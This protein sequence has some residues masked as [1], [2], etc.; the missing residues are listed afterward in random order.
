[1][2]YYLLYLAMDERFIS[3]KQRRKMER[4]QKKERKDTFYRN[5][6]KNKRGRKTSVNSVNSDG[7]KVEESDMEY[8]R[9]KMGKKVEE[10]GK[11]KEIKVKGKVKDVKE[12]DDIDL[13]LEYLEGK[14]GLDKEENMKALSKIY[15][16]ENH[17]PDILDFLDNIDD[18]VTKDVEYY[19]NKKKMKKATNKVEEDEQEE[20]EEG[21]DDEEIHSDEYEDKEED[22]DENEGNEDENI[23]SDEH[24]DNE[25]D[26]NDDEE[27]QPQTKKPPIRK[28]EPAKPKPTK[29]PQTQNKQPPPPITQFQKEITSLLNKISESN[30]SILLPTIFSKITTLT[31]LHPPLQIYKTLTTVSIN[32]LSHPTTSLPI[33]SCICTFLSLCHYKYGDSFLLY[34]LHSLLT[35]INYFIPSPEHPKHKS[36]NAIFQLIHFYLFK[37]I[38]SSLIYDLILYFIENF[39]EVY[40]EHLLLLLSY[41]GISIRKENPE[42]LMLI[43]SEINKK[44]NNMTLS[45]TNNDNTDT[46]VNKVKY[47]IDMIDDIK[48]NKYLKFNLS[49]KFAF[50]VN[51]VQSNVNGSE[52]AKKGESIETKL[53]SIKNID[54]DNL[55]TSSSISSNNDNKNNDHIGL[56]N[57]QDE[58]LPDD[59]IDNTLSIKLNNKMK[60]LNIS[61]NLKKL[62][63]T[64]I[65]TSHNIND[66]FER[67]T[68]LNLKGEQNREVIKMILLLCSEEKCF[69]PFYK[70]LLEKLMSINKDHKYTYHYCIWDYMKVFN[71]YND[72]ELKKI[73]NISKLT[74]KL[75]VSE[76]ISFPV[77]LPFKFEESD[78]K[79]LMFVVFVLDDYFEEVN[80]VA[81]VKI[82]FAK[83]IKNDEHVEFGKRLCYF[84]MNGFV[85][86]VDL[87][88]K[89]DKYMENY[90]AA[91]KLLKKIL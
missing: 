34:Y 22:E 7:K 73:H 56:T 51:Y 32:L 61:T 27:E 8:I 76:K 64:T 66:A 10:K 57:E 90:S 31:S 39:N 63:F 88:E 36:K 42:N 3:R 2:D 75:L 45:I 11:G 12:K 53:E 54:I 87:N 59:I 71:T 23:Q 26:D 47:I 13:D 16:I 19:N 72:N 80:S 41:T 52:S 68:R 35:S 38:T 1:M 20:E 33:T 40:S 30:L 69:N 44:Y 65:S 49:D 43:I 83:L 78:D 48:S 46:N 55:L 62:I 89:G 37:N 70:H 5:K 85:N 25:D 58:Y 50:F 74:A 24:E 15:T 14:L 29:P 60:R 17:D 82:Q 67:I 79:T 91:V 9:K 84:L 77:L 81:N 6:S 18:I 21:D 86:E 28:T 4:K